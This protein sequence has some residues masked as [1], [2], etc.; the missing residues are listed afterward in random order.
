MLLLLFQ[1]FMFSLLLKLDK[2]KGCF[3]SVKSGV[4]LGWGDIGEFYFFSFFIVLFG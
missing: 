1:F 4:I 3:Q 2:L